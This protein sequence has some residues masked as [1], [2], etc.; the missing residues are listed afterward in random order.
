MP[1]EAERIKD[2]QFLK[3]KM[4]MIKSMLR[5]RTALKFRLSNVINHDLRLEQEFFNYR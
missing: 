5:L 4:E 2:L 3:A 1:C